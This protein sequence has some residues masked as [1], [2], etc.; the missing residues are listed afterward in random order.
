LIGKQARERGITIPMMG[1]DGWDSPEL[2]LAAVEGG[3]FSNHYSVADPRPVVQDFIKKYTDTYGAA[4][5]ALAV[6]A[7]DAAN[8]LMQSIDD[9]K[10]ADPTVVKDA[11]QN[12]KFEGVSGNITFDN[13]GDPI[14][15][16]ALT[17]IKDGKLELV[18]FVAP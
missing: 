2:D 11:M 10:S 15:S 7:Y 8:I 5:D 6:L 12:I 4:P 9:A 16:A 14:K 18:R 17:A 1:G 3:Y 13:K